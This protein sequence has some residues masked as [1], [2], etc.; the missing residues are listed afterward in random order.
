MQIL[1]IL[2]H[3]DKCVRHAQF[4]MK[5]ASYTGRHVNLE[6]SSVHSSFSLSWGFKTGVNSSTL[7]IKSFIFSGKN[8]TAPRA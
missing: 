2:R 4:A 5:I 1:L 6:G 3:E 8:N 7:S